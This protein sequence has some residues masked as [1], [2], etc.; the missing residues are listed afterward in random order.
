MP[1]GSVGAASSSFPLPLGEGRVRGSG[2][3]HAHGPLPCPKVPHPSP[4]PMGEGGKAAGGA[5]S[6]PSRKPAAVTDVM[7][8][9]VAWPRMPQS[10]EPL[11]ASLDS[12]RGEGGNVRESDLL[13]SLCHKWLDRLMLPC[14]AIPPFTSITAR[15]DDK[16]CAK[17]EARSHRPSTGL[18]ALQ[19]G[20][21][22]LN[23]EEPVLGDATG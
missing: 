4:L 3:Q 14:P 13:K 5:K 21:G 16:K 23:H 10:D 2:T 1:G 22:S 7:R 19:E 11:F 20:S 6:V 12:Y 8:P 15:Q 18:T 9:G 17:A